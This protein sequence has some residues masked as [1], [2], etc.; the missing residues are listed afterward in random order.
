MLNNTKSAFRPVAVGLVATNKKRGTPNIRVT[1]IE[2]FSDLNSDIKDQSEEVESSGLGADNKPFKIKISRGIAIDAEWLGET[3]R[4]LSPDVRRNEQVMLYQSGDSN[5]YYWT[6]MGRDDNLRRLETL[7][8]AYN[9][10]PSN[11]DADPSRDNSYV[12][13]ISTHDGH[14]T[15]TTSDKNGEKAKYLFQFNTKDGRV[16]LEDNLGNFIFLDSVE[17]DIHLQNGDTSF[18]RMLKEDI[19]IQSNKSINSKT[20]TYNIECDNF[21]TKSKNYT[22]TTSAYKKTASTYSVTVPL[23]SFSTMVGCTTLAAAA[24]VGGSATGASGGPSSMTAGVTVP[25][26]KSVAVTGPVTASEVTAQGITLTGH[27]HGS[28]GSGTPV[29]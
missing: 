28:S 13:E 16:T 27:R 14:I 1:P 23:A 22:E 10:D 21:N 4:V 15:L 9:G 25:N 3:N 18:F 24:F 17:R 20:K 6:S 26:G 29:P 7:V 5:K 8:W 12:Q 11:E 2:I 19:F